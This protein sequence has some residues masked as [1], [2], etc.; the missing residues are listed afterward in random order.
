MH[1]FFF[2]LPEMWVREKV[3]HTCDLY[4]HSEILSFYIN[5]IE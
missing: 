2:F 5:F 1:C 4:V 3:L